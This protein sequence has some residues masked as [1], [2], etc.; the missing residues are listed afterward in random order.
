MCSFSLRPATP[1]LR[2]VW[3]TPF[4]GPR[5]G[6]NSISSFAVLTQIR[7]G[8]HRDHRVRAGRKRRG[9]DDCFIISTTPSL[10]SW[11]C[12]QNLES[13]RRDRRKQRVGTHHYLRQKNPRLGLT[14][15]LIT[16][17]W[18]FSCERGGRTLPFRSLRQFSGKNVQMGPSRRPPP[19]ARPQGVYSRRGRRSAT[20][21]R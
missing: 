1:L 6:A 7:N 8:R 2:S 14:Q 18:E 19:A 10:K 13:N 5:G 20:L 3:S 11:P 12:R 9:R 16:G 15:N 17:G 21:L 4:P